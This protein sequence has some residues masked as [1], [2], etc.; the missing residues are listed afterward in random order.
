MKILS[1]RGYWKAPIEKNTREAFVRSFA[2]GFGTETD[3]R[4]YMGELVI[5]HDIPRGG[6]INFDAFLVKYSLLH[7]S[8]SVFS[9][10][11]LS[12]F[13]P[14]LNGIILKNLQ[15]NFLIIV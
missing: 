2:L 4:D 3:I 7:H 15:L 11:E 8:P 14:L 12:G 1:H 5:S 10:S 9:S 6:E 13:T